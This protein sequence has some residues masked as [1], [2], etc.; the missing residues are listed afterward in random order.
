MQATISLEK[1]IVTPNSDWPGK[2]L[3][4]AITK[5]NI[6]N[7]HGRKLLKLRQ[8]TCGASVSVTFNIG[9][10]IPPSPA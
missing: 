3:F 10:E 9:N 8:T 2:K 7:D 4:S 5:I 1:W 6:G